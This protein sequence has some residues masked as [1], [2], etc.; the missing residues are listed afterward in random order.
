M[1]S[2]ETKELTL[3]GMAF[4]RWS[5]DWSRAQESG[6][7]RLPGGGR[8]A[9]GAGTKVGSMEKQGGFKALANCN[10]DSDV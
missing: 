2:V 7:N 5:G 8:S 3:E 6:F 9:Q 10:G 1:S 4:L